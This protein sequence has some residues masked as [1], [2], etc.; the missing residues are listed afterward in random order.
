MNV[1]LRLHATDTTLFCVCRVCQERARALSVAA[2][3]VRA[4]LAATEETLREFDVPRALEARQTRIASTAEVRLS[5]C[6]RC[7]GG[8]F[9]PRPCADAA[10]HAAGAVRAGAVARVRP[11]EVRRA[12][13]RLLAGR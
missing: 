3:N 9:T 12:V 13:A 4:A 8:A 10:P 7:A 5:R 11:A 2:D 6:A 1:L